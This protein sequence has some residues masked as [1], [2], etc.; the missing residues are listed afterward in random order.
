MFKILER[1][2]VTLETFYILEYDNT[3]NKIENKA[4]SLYV[5]KSWDRF[6]EEH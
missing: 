5:S 1:I 2:F 4:I 6:G 3:E